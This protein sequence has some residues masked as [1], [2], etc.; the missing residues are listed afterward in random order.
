M[1]L[2]LIDYVAWVVTI[3]VM[4]VLFLWVGDFGL[5]PYL[6]QSPV[7]QYVENLWRITYVSASGV[8]GVFMGSLIFLSLRFRYVEETAQRQ[9]TRTDYSKI[10]IPILLVSGV[11][12]AYAMFQYTSNLMEFQF[13]FGILASLMI[14][15]FAA[16]IFVVYKQYYE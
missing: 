9:A 3:A 5:L 1:K 14:L 13:D 12:L 7:S 6:A 16:F 15:L 11:S 10:V 8:F 2:R 4:W